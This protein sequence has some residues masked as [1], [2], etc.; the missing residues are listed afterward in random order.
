MLVETGAL[1]GER[2][3]HRLTRPIQALE[4]PATVPVILAARIDRLSAEDKELLQMA[5]VIGKDVPS[6]LL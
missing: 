1:A 5:S 6:V 2:G 3:T 4:V